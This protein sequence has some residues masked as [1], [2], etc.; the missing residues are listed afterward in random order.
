VILHL[1]LCSLAVFWLWEVLL[2]WV[3]V[4]SALRAFLVAGLG[5]WAYAYWPDSVLAALSIATAVGLLHR[6]AVGGDP[7]LVELRLPRRSKSY[8]PGVGNRIPDLP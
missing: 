2:S 3:P 4:T 5:Y 7:D 8:P 1:V 6:Y